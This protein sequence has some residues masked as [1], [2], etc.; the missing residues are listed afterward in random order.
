MRTSA[1]IRVRSGGGR[2][3]PLIAR[4]SGRIRRHHM[5]LAAVILGVVTIT[6]LGRAFLA[7]GRFP[8]RVVRLVGHFERVPRPVLVAAIAPY[9]HQN[10]YALSLGEV[11]RSVSAVPWVGQ[12]RVQRRF[13]RTLVVD[14]GPE[15]LVARWGLG[16]W[17]TTQGRHVHLQGYHLPRTLPVFAGPAGH[18]TSMASHYQRFQSLLHPLGLAIA[19]LTL[20]HRATWRINL[21]NG[22]LLVL[23]RSASARL[24]RF[25]TIFPQ[26][27]DRLLSMRRI[28]LRYTNGFAVGWQNASED[29]HD[30]KG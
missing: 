18:E 5:I 17:V 11:Q 10:F 8:V 24:A 22:P 28:D 25:I 15:D 1:A 3:A 26:I 12:V 20:S 27:S 21:R 6:L 2:S 30:Q 23:G 14:V 29:Q 7:P 13:P 9:L 4:F 16:G 19:G